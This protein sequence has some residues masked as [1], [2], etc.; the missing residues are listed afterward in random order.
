LIGL[1][2]FSLADIAAA[3]GAIYYPDFFAG[4]S[5]EGEK[6]PKYTLAFDPIQHLN[7]A[8][9]E[10]VAAKLTPIVESMLAKRQSANSGAVGHELSP[11]TPPARPQSVTQ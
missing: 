4:V 5:H 7:A 1:R 3:N 6:E 2:T 11:P 10:V 8:G 9:Y